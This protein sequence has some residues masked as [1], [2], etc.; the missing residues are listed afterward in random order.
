[1][2]EHEIT[3][4]WIDRYNEGELDEQEKELFQQRMNASPLLHS[5]VLL[6]ASLNRFLCDE[7]LLDLMKKIK[8]VTL[9]TPDAGRLKNILLIAASVLLFV[10]TSGL[11]YLFL[12]NIPTPGIMTVQD[13]GKPDQAKNGG[14]DT[15]S[16]TAEG[17]NSGKNALS[18]M[19]DAVSQ[20]LLSFNFRPLPELELLTGSVTR[21]EP[22]QLL[23]P[24]ALV[25]ARSGTDVIFEWRYNGKTDSLSMAILNNLGLTVA[26][27]SLD[28][29]GS[30]ILN[31]AR[32]GEGLYYWKI[33]AA[34]DFVFMGKLIIIKEIKN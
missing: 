1:M 27:L 3:C 30:F 2:K 15:L 5:E 12:T 18:S 31:T 20:D 29:T 22:F 33:L 34:D 24:N 23:S 32:F 7:E 21:S 26:R 6:D 8:D 11:F 25:Y 4:D 13:A 17:Q 14:H 28:H 10:M 19:P 9:R 16:F